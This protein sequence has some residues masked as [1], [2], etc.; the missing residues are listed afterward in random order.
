MDFYFIVTMSIWERDDPILTQFASFKIGI[1]LQM[2]VVMRGRK[3][4]QQ[5]HKIRRTT[6]INFLLCNGNN[7]S[8]N[9][10]VKTTQT[11]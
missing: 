1:C 11:R 6:K 7:Y 3:F 2:V 9:L 10:R 4:S 5:I 8:N